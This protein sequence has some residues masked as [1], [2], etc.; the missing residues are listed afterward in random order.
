MTRGDGTWLET[1]EHLIARFDV[2]AKFD[3]NAVHGPA[4][5][6]AISAL[7]RAMADRLDYV[8][9]HYQPK[10]GHKPFSW[11]AGELGNL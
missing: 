10:P 9:E 2:A 5:S 7:M 3:A 11:R 6:A 4:G 8:V 1:V